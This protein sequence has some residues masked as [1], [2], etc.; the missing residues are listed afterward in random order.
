MRR[1]FSLLGA[2]LLGTA[3]AHAQTS[4]PATLY[5]QH[6]A[7]CHA[8]NRSG[9]MGPALLPDSLAR[10][11]KT[12]AL[13]AIAEGRVGT[14]MPAFSGVLG[15]EEIA[16]LSEW[17]YAPAPALS[18]NESDIRA[19]R[20]QVTDP[21]T[22]A[23]RP[24]FKADP[25]N[26][27]IVVEAGDHHVSILDGD[28]LEPIHRFASRYA[29]HGGPKFSPDGRHVYFASRDGW[30]SK[31]DIWNLKLVAEVRAGI[32]TRN[33]AVSADGRYVMV[34]NY[35]PGNLVL[36]D[37]ELRLVKIIPAQSLDGKE[38]SRVSAVYDAAPRKSFVAAMKDMPEVWEISYD[39][40]AAPIFDGYVHDYKM[41]EGI[42]LPGF[43]NPR[44]TRLDTVL[45]D[46]FFDQTYRNVM[47]SSREGKG[48]VVNLDVR[49]KIG[50]LDL[51]GMPHLGS[52]IT[53]QRDGR[54]VMASTNLRENA[55]TVIDM[56]DWKKI[57]SIPT[58]GPGFFLRSHENSRYAWADSM[59]SPSAKDT[60]YVIDKQTLQVVR[61]LRPEPGKTLAHIEFT[62][63]GRHALA[64]LW[65]MD[66]ALIVY[67]AQTLAEVKRI[68]MKKPVGK[69]NLWNKIKRSEGTSH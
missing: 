24:V 26:L 68:P 6:C 49:R 42:A 27:F 56:G 64:S 43:L 59:M 22:L 39:E 35:L 38:Q 31:F 66:G 40:Q 11:K 5:Q 32:N 15:K 44:R 8:A 23:A 60:L 50:D 55:I 16:A 63:D 28:R 62:R 36:L 17:I 46:F 4:A 34:A 61:E 37:A 45:D 57:A 41:K 25:M 1:A 54:T 2:L 14:Q 21:H 51:S 30:I 3:A 69:Y 52:G 33:A 53:W 48:Q 9:A 19:S 10:L 12:E 18:W 13:R 58:G 20:I 7:A 29:L 65:E 67:D 47:G